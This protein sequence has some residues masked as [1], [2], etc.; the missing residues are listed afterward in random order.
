[1]K[2]TVIGSDS[3]HKLI[4]EN[5][6][7]DVA[8]G[9]NGLIH[10]DNKHEGDGK[11][12]IGT[13]P[14]RCLY[15]RADRITLPPCSLN[16]TPIT[17]QMGWCDDPGHA[18]YNRLVDLPFDGSHEAMWREDHAYDIVI[19]LGYNDDTPEAGRGSAIFFHLLHDDKIETAGCIAI[20]RDEMLAILPKI[21][22]SSVV[23]I[24]D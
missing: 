24:K 15:Y 5:I 16:T 14:V 10:T 21:T 1:M 12:P 18:S 22:P 3:R 9:C 7:C 17:E 23:D 6:Q 20:P 4:A 11:T 19:P 8:V 13:W 2:I